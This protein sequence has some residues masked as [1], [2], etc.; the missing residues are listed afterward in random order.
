MA[1]FSTSPSDCLVE[2]EVEKEEG[3]E[4]HHKK[5]GK[6]DVVRQIDGIILYLTW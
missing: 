2:E 1:L 4:G 5:V 6:E 3:D